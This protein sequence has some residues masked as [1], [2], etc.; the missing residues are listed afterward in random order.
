MR[1]IFCVGRNYFK[2]CLVIKG[3]FRY[4][5]CFGVFDFEEFSFYKIEYFRYDVVGKWFNGDVYIV[6]CFVVIMVC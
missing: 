4:F 2:V 6:D 5:V 3:N 1:W